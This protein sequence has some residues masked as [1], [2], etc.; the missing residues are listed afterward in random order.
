VFKSI[1]IY[2]LIFILLASCKSQS[3]RLDQE[4]KRQIINPPES[5]GLEVTNQAYDQ[6]VKETPQYLPNI[7]SSLTETET[8]RVMTES[9]YT[10][11]RTYERFENLTRKIR[12]IHCSCKAWGTCES[13]MCE[14][15][16]LCPTGMG[17]F[18]RDEN[19]A[20]N[21]VE[22]SL[23]FTNEDSTK[24]YKKAGGFCTGH[25][26]LTQRFNR[27][28][29]F[30][31]EAA[32]PF[33]ESPKKR[34]NYYKEQIDKIVNNQPADISGYANLQ[35]FSSDPAIQEYLIKKVQ[36][37]WFASTA[38]T[39]IN[40]KDHYDIGKTTK[41]QAIKDIKGRLENFQ[42]PL[43][44][45][46]NK[47]IGRHVVLAENIYEVGDTTYLCIRD[48]NGMPANST[49]SKCASAIV[50]NKESARSGDVEYGDIFVY[51]TENAD[52]VEQQQNLSKKCADDK[53]CHAKAAVVEETIED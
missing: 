1:P 23:T 46:E 4:I 51:P 11:N 35:E 14:C 52:V 50:I 15:S 12:D 28:A 47:E 25:A 45:V 27:L 20:M 31:K 9:C 36:D 42:Q 34:I 19:L 39:I 44:L 8:S 7:N 26:T 24:G 41:A 29:F 43:I 53:N 16:I 37:I 21:A 3:K 32:K 48:N 18:K 38:T 22:N 40:I 17:I 5:A 10:E 2:L 6:M 49:P 30:H 13:E 33:P